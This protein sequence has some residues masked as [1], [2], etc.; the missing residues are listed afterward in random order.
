MTP[1]IRIA[2]VWRSD[3]GGRLVTVVPRADYERFR[4][5]R[6]W[7]LPAIDAQAIF[8]RGTTDAI[9]MA[10]ADNFVRGRVLIERGGVRVDDVRKDHVPLIVCKIERDHAGCDNHPADGGGLTWI[11]LDVVAA[12]PLLARDGKAVT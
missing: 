10:L 12:M 2:D 11:P 6:Y 9:M 4:L 8:Y 5:A 3:K 7:S 1:D